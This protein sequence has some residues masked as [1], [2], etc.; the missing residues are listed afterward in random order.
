MLLDKQGYNQSP[1]LLSYTKIYTNPNK[2]SKLLKGLVRVINI[3]QTVPWLF[4]SYFLD[5]VH[6]Y[7]LLFHTTRYYTTWYS[8]KK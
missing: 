3:R 7:S 5:M 4:A 6:N 2:Q 8:C 1:M